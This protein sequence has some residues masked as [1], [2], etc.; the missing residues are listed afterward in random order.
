MTAEVLTKGTLRLEKF[1]QVIL[2]EV[3]LKKL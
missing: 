1:E 2:L 3:E